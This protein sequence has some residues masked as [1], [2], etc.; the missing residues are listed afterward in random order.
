MFEEVFKVLVQSN[1]TKEKEKISESKEL[2][3]IF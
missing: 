3:E 1:I 2:N